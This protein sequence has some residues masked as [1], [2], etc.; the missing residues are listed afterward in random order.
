MLSKKRV[1][2]VRLLSLTAML[3]AAHVWAD[4]QVDRVLPG[5]L[6]LAIGGDSQSFV[7]RGSKLELVK[8]LTVAS[9]APEHFSLSLGPVVKKGTER[10]VLI[11]ATEEAPAGIYRVRVL[12]T[13]RG[14]LL[15]DPRLMKLIVMP[16]EVDGRA[17]RKQGP[18]GRRVR[19]PE[20]PARRGDQGASPSTIDDLDIDLTA[21]T[22]VEPTLPAPIA[23]PEREWGD[24]VPGEPEIVDGGG[25]PLEPDVFDGDE[26]LEVEAVELRDDIAAQRR[27][28]AGTSGDIREPE[29]QVNVGSASSTLTRAMLAEAM[30]EASMVA[31]A[32]AVR[33]NSVFPESANRSSPLRLERGNSGAPFLALVTPSAQKAFIKGYFPPPKS[34]EKKEL[35][36]A[37]VKPSF[38]DEVVQKS[39][40]IQT[41]QPGEASPDVM[42]RKPLA[43]PTPRIVRKTKNGLPSGQA[44]SKPVG[45]RSAVDSKNNGSVGAPVSVP[46]IVDGE[47]VTRREMVGNNKAAENAE[48]TPV[49]TASLVG[50]RALPVY[51]IRGMA[52]TA[53]LVGAVRNAE[54]G[55]PVAG[56]ELQ[57]GEMVAQTTSRGIYSLPSGERS[58]QLKVTAEGYLPIRLTA[59]RQSGAQMDELDV[60]LRPV[61]PAK[62]DV[63]LPDLMIVSPPTTPL[64]RGAKQNVRFRIFNA[65]GKPVKNYD[66]TLFARIW[67][68][69]D[70]QEGRNVAP[71]TINGPPLGAGETQVVDMPINI[72]A[73]SL[74]AEL[75]AEADA[76]DRFE[77]QRE[78]NNRSN[79][80]RIV[81]ASMP[82]CEAADVNIADYALEPSLSVVESDGAQGC[83]LEAAV[84]VANYSNEDARPVTVTMT[85]S[86]SDDVLFSS[87]LET[88]KMRAGEVES[89]R[90]AAPVDAVLRALSR[91]L[92]LPSLL[93]DQSLTLAVEVNADGRQRERFTT[94]NRIDFSG[95][96]SELVATENLLYR[97]R[98]EVCLD[99]L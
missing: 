1:W 87:S 36:A 97:K 64:C 69:G 2:F 6:E 39:R 92:S 80:R 81:V 4:P 66:V 37:P 40:G 48:A 85:L 7:L 18:R 63:A 83:Q 47:A 16:S 74:W 98:G 78:S 15:L 94:N 9:A 45:E 28:S 8:E 31:N 56:A 77:E 24:D 35:G 57:L 96:L 52:P 14:G 88:K 65:G 41:E 32:I 5:Y 90:F 75:T 76:N 21:T 79:P 70:G 50:M 10:R 86:T 99:K 11:R 12:Y 33:A 27:L 46:A 3:F 20:G 43:T 62:R 60:S 93:P 34:T 84:T 82:D 29:G 53:M 25:E 22:N 19:T 42:T 23:L 17:D 51:W 30:G 95:R 72:P 49:S 38:A 58:R 73:D 91:R 55:E 13:T 61:E 59:P 71:V 44:K 54:T 68:E 26:E 67:K 89:M